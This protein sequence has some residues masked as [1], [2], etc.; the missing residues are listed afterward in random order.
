MS[1]P[2]VFIVGC[3]RSGTTLFRHMVNAH[4]R[5]AITPEAQWIPLWF[6]ERRG[7][8]PEGMVTPELVPQLL[9]EPK[10]ALLRMG[11]AE[12]LGLLGNGHPV[13]YAAFVSGIF[14]LYGK[15]EGKALVGN[16]T[17]DYARRMDT[18]RTL[19]PGV[20]FIH[21]IR[22]GRDVALSLMAW[23]RV[24][25]KR[26]GTLATWKDDPVRTAALWWEL[27]VRSGRDGAQGLGPKLYHEIRYE[28]LVARPVEVC[29]EVCSFLD[30]PY[31]DAMLRFHEAQP[32]AGAPEVPAKTEWQPVTAG[33]RDWRT[34]MSSEDV[35]R[36]EATV[37][38]LLDE[39]GY[40][41]AV[42]RPRPESLEG[43]ASVRDAFAGC[44]GGATK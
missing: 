31:D 43:A 26:P 19:W 5:L 2:Y 40:P 18:L 22:D 33:L 23:P 21:L 17:P 3:P 27:N 9:A 16:K 24:S 13:S 12:L 28:S 4:P 20:R 37:G 25:K 35:E 1:N 10:F 38:G 8:T 11:R 41:R 14:D 29:R 42:P 32:K 39:L 30:L 7:L 15:A 6:K 36:F 34:Q 44:L